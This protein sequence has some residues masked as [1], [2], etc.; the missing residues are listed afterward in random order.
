MQLLEVSAAVRPLKWPFGVKWLTAT[1]SVCLI[2]I[3]SRVATLNDDAPL[4]R[5]TRIE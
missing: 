3:L 4:F 5:G 2:S 1:D